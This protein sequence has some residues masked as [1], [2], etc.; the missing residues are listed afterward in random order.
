MQVVRSD[1]GS[2]RAPSENFT[3]TVF[4][5]VVA[6]PTGG[7]RIRA[8]NVHFAPGG[9]TAWHTHPLGQTIYITEGV[10]HVQRRGD[11]I[12]VVRAGDIVFFEPGEVH[13]HGA[14]PNRFMSHIA[15]VEV[16]DEGKTADW[17]ELVSDADYEAAPRLEP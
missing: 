9:R 1:V 8:S 4:S 5:E 17:G 2:V 15:M 7:S 11:P 13:W 16:D 3:G 6:M 14:S 12:E 10:G